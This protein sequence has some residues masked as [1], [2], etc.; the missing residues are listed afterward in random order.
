[1]SLGQQHQPHRMGCVPRLLLNLD[2][3]CFGSLTTRTNPVTIFRIGTSIIDSL[4]ITCRFFLNLLSLLLREIFGGF[5]GGCSLA[6]AYSGSG[7]LIGLAKSDRRGGDSWS[8]RDSSLTV[9][10]LQS[11]LEFAEFLTNRQVNRRENDG[12]S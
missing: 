8:S 2:T 12:K 6:F 5:G 11:F 3:I 7:V 10:V 9:S 1:M 4:C